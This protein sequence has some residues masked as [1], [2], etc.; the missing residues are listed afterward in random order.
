MKKG[1]G[2]PI[3]LVAFVIFIALVGLWWTFVYVPAG[4]IGILDHL[5]SVDPNPIPPGMHY[6]GFTSKI[7]VMDT[8]VQKAQ[9]DTTAASKDLQDVKAQLAVNYQIIPAQAPTIYKELGLDYAETVIHPIVQETIKAEMAKYNAEELISNREQVVGGIR[10]ALSAKLQ[11][12]G[13]QVAEVSITNFDFSEAFNKAIEDKQVAQQKAL[14]A[15]NKLQETNYTAQGL[16]LQA[17]VI[18]IKRLDIQQALIEKWDGHLPQYMIVSQGS[19]GMFM[20]L[21][22]G[23][24]GNNGST[25]SGSG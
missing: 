5:G 24:V 9:Y 17:K 7:E 1:Q 19:Q 15:Y 20:Q 18:E 4:S 13:I 25:E 8:R 14:E 21:P 23:V 11:E 3:I 2:S 22:Q 10:D 6:A 16:S 12:R